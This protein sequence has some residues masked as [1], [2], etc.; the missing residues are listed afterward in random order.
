MDSGSV[1]IENSSRAHAESLLRTLRAYKAELVQQNGSWQVDVQLGEL[2]PWLRDLFE[3]IGA[4]LTSEQVDSVV[5][6]FDE[7]Q[8]TLL[9]PSRERA[10]DSSGLLLE[11]VAQ[12]ETALESR[13]VI[14]QAKG[15]IAREFGLSI[16]AAFNALREAARSSR[17]KIHDLAREIAARPMEAGTIV[18]TA[19][20]T[21]PRER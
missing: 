12:L 11:R 6:H 19:V 21:P 3:G 4:W 10:Q 15:V 7:R 16:D 9:R 18:R 2:G 1:R 17:T 14:E 20:R 13:V 8:Y 5:L